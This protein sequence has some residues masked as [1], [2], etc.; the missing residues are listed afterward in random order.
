M[1]NHTEDL[2][3]KIKREFRNIFRQN[4]LRISEQRDA[5]VDIFFSTE[6]HLSIPDIM[7]ELKRR[8]VE[9]SESTVKRIMKLLTEYGIAQERSFDGQMVRYEHEHVG[10]HHDHLICLR[11]RKIIEF[12]DDDLEMIQERIAHNH[13]FHL[14]RHK[15][16]M[17]G[18]CPECFGKEEDIVSLWRVQEGD[19]FKVV[20]LSGGQHI[21]KR[22]ESL[23]IY[24]GANGQMIRN[25]GFGQMVL[26][27]SGSR[28]AL[29]HGMSRRVF[30]S[31]T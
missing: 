8:N 19:S 1:A 9:V 7:K 4:G 16:E 23:G 29:G 10:E 15:M 3:A 28:I 18:I 25:R 13:R 24:A 14:I 26:A 6:H 27:I 2:N 17:Y 12:E 31:I 5:V 11:C 22:L 21:R 20:E 30:V